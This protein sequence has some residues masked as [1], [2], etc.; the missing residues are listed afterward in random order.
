MSRRANQVETPGRVA[1]MPLRLRTTTPSIR[2]ARCM[3]RCAPAGYR[4]RRMRRVTAW[5]T[6][7]ASPSSATARSSPRRADLFEPRR[8]GPGSRSLS[9]RRG[10]GASALH[11]AAFQQGHGRRRC[12]PP[13]RHP[14]RRQPDHRRRKRG[15][16]SATARSGRRGPAWIEKFYGFL[17]VKLMTADIPPCDVPS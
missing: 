13:D 5:N 1:A 9:R 16:V 6:P 11:A 10:C 2:S 3:P 7:C 12:R 4:R 15:A 14:L 17:A 8:A